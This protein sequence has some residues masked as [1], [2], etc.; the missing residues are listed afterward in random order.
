MSA[1]GRVEA[2]WSQV[3][4]GR[5]EAGEA[6]AACGSR[7]A[8][9]TS[10]LPAPPPPEHATAWHSAPEA[11]GERQPHITRDKAS[12]LQAAALLAG[13]S[14]SRSPPQTVVGGAFVS[15]VLYSWFLPDAGGKELVR[16]AL[17]SASAGLQQCAAADVGCPELFGAEDRSRHEGAC[18]YLCL[19]P[20]L[21]QQRREL[22]ESRLVEAEPAALFSRG[23]DFERSGDSFQAE[24]CYRIAA[25]R[26]FVPAG[27]ARGNS[28]LQFSANVVL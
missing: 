6:M 22:E 1:H 28:L 3:A 18:P 5:A 21:A 23:Y 11:Q 14:T 26:S 10:Q 13:L 16:L 4:G 17:P 25:Q 12:R 19:R 24:I 9:S 15:C 7:C 2:A 8:F 20:M 27:Y